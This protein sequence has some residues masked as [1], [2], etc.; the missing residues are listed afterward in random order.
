MADITHGTWIKD[1][2]AVDKVFSNGKQVYGRNLIKN[3]DIMYSWV[4]EYNIII[5]DGVFVYVSASF[6]KG[7]Y[8][9]EAR[10]IDDSIVGADFGWQWDGALQG[11]SIKLSKDWQKATALFEY[12]IPLGLRV[13]GGLGLIELRFIKAEQGTTATPYSVAPEDLLK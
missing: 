12:N 11:E 4:G 9:I 13:I 10:A 5:K 3:G 2:K 6:V 8:Q 7:M 1:G